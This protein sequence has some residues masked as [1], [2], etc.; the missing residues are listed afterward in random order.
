LN[1]IERRRITA[2]VLLL[3]VLAA[4]VSL[5]PASTTELD[6]YKRPYEQIDLS[7]DFSAPA[8]TDTISLVSV[9][10]TNQKGTDSTSAIIATS[11]VPAVVPST[12]KV[13]FRVTGGA[14][15]DVHTIVIRVTL[16]TSGQAL[17]GRITLHVSGAIQ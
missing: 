16:V 14:I 8:G 15:G 13:A 10:A 7:Y 1:S 4:C 2:A 9:R 11:P 17:E 3:T 5:L 6:V 12:N